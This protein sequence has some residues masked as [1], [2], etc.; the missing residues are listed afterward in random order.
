[1]LAQKTNSSFIVTCNTF[2][3]FTPSFNIYIHIT[4]V[5]GSSWDKG[6]E[7][8]VNDEDYMIYFQMLSFSVLMFNKIVYFLQTCP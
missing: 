5:L 8:G 3:L 6:R 4:F 7:G 1:M 2:F